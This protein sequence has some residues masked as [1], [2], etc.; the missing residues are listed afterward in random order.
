MFEQNIPQELTS[1]QKQ[2]LTLLRK[3]LT[4]NEICKNLNISANTVKAHLANIYKILEVTNRTEAA[5]AI[6][7]EKS[8][9]SDINKDVNIIFLKQNDITAYPK[10]NGLY[11]SLVEAIH[12][13]RIFRI[14]D[15]IEGAK[16]PAFTIDV[17]A[18]KDKDESLFL[19]IRL[20][21][22]HE[23]LWTTS[24]KVNSDNILELAQKSAMLLFRN[25]VLATANIKY[26]PSSPI[27]YWWYVVAHCTIKFENRSK[28]SFNYCK[29]LLT[30]LATGEVY[31]EQ[32]IYTLALVYYIAALDN[33][34]DTQE[35]TKQ[36][37][38]FAKKT[39]FNA[40]YSIYSQMI[41][42]FYNIVIG[43]KNEAIAYFKQVIE[44][45]PQTIIARTILI[46]IYMLTGQNE[47]ALELIDESERLIPET[48]AQASI[49]HGR[50][51]ILLL[52]GK[53]EECINLAKQIL[54]YTPKAT[55]FH[56]FIIFCYNKLGKTEESEAQIS[57]LYKLHPNFDKP[58]L[59]QL[60][61]G[62]NPQMQKLFMD[63][64][65]NLFATN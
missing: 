51:L 50:A 11:Y 65:Q 21:S 40:P 7:D 59:E 32:A 49:K 42:A 9:T 54:L 8:D 5:S 34:G 46:Q 57:E 52:Q 35:Y 37:A 33:W 14:T 38:E 64:L 2:I 29:S 30:P 4:N 36:L 27:P 15:T 45:N 55:I 18:A 62:V 6:L 20:G 3:G 28:D 53:Y 60:M 19:S 56:I 10:A 58:Y 26:T 43:N 16:Q 63:N 1:R 17:S 31:N 41:M 24:I 39:M 61:K 22:T 13:Y 25:I 44:A 23:M 47:K 48:A 12:Q